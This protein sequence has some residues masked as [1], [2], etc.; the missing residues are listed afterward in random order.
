MR[1][2]DWSSDVCSSDLIGLRMQLG[3]Q[4]ADRGADVVRMRDAHTVGDV[5][6]ITATNRWQRSV[7]LVHAVDLSG[8]PGCRSRSASHS[9]ENYRN[10]RNPVRFRRSTAHDPMRSEEHTSELQSLMRISYAV[11]SLKKK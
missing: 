3:E 6:M 10:F 2:S 8:P 5:V 11:F 7:L 1:I 9:V 4:C